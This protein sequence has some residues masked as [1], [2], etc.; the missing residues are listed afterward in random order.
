METLKRNC[1]CCGADSGQIIP[2][3]KYSVAGV[4]EIDA[5]LKICDACGCL[6]Q[7]PVPAPEA[8][9]KYYKVLSNYTN[10]SRDGLPDPNTLKANRR[11]LA[12]IDDLPKLGRAYEIGCATGHMLSELKKLGW[13]VNGCDP[14]P[15]AAKVAKDLWDIQIQTGQFE[16]MSLAPGGVDLVLMMHVLEHVHNPVDFLGKAASLLAENGSLLIEVPCLIRPDKWGNGYF[17]FEHINI[18]S[19]NALLS[20]LSRAGF[21]ALAIKIDAESEP[22]PV[23]T[24]LARKTGANKPFPV[25]PDDPEAVAAMVKAYLKTDAS[26]WMRIDNLLAN[27]LL[28]VDEVILWGGGVHTSQLFSHTAA[29]HAVDI[30]YVIDS[31]PQKHGLKI[32]GVE[33]RGIDFVSLVND[34]V[35]IIISSKA[36][37][38]EIYLY[39][40]K[41]LQLKTK[42][43]RLYN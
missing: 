13:N 4:G 19:E 7:D 29:I 6:M 14:S 23:I 1:I 43:V 35:P 15:S 18:F 5:K 39:L 34:I 36:Y 27:E 12:L 8:M 28:G 16:E 30:K 17:T 9:A 38:E 42:I 31:D 40:R 37:E 2:L 33:I 25:R 22:Y 3:G 41:E 24:A 20:C 26:E 10:A 21:Q 32:E 11:Q